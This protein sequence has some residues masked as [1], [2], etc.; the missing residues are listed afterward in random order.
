MNEV[1]KIVRGYAYCIQAELEGIECNGCVYSTEDG[2]QFLSDE[3]DEDDTVTLPI[4]LALKAL[5]ILNNRAPV[6]PIYKKGNYYCGMC[7]RHIIS[8]AGKND[9]GR[10]EMRFCPSCGQAVYWC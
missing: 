3:M 2:C 7:N 6:E 1:D 8:V 5:T 9:Q 4:S 10:L